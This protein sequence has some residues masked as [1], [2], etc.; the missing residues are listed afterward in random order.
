VTNVAGKLES[1]VRIRFSFENRFCEVNEGHLGS[2]AAREGSKGRQ[3]GKEAGE[4]SKALG[5]QDLI[6][7][8]THTTKNRNNKSKILVAKH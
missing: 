8:Q 7:K 3:Q 2:K 5:S 4:G 6:L 1:D